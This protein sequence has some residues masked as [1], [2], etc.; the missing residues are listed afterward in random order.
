MCKYSYRHGDRT[1]VAETPSM[2]AVLARPL[3][4]ELSDSVSLGLTPGA[5]SI[6]T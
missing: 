2:Q 5:I 3:N 4:H 1:S 6:L